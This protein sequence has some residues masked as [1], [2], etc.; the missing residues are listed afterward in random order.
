[1][2]KL[3]TSVPD[4]LRNTVESPV[5]L[6][7][8]VC[9]GGICEGM[10]YWTSGLARSCALDAGCRQR[11]SAARRRKSD[12]ST[13]PRPNE[14]NEPVVHIE[15]CYSRE[16]PE[17]SYK[18]TRTF[19]W[20]PHVELAC[21]SAAG[22][23]LLR[24]IGVLVVLMLAV[25]KVVTVVA[26]MGSC[27]CCAAHDLQVVVCVRVVES[28]SNGLAALH[29]SMAQVGPSARHVIAYGM[30]LC[31]DSARCALVI[32]SPGLM[33]LPAAVKEAGR[34]ALGCPRNSR[35]VWHTK[36]RAKAQQMEK[37]LEANGTNQLGP[38][39]ALGLCL[40]ELRLSASSCEVATLANDGRRLSE[41]LSA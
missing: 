32:S 24:L 33:V 2:R 35:P 12:P 3:V 34:E 16:C 18:L 22:R 19:N 38:R 29:R 39:R 41:D 17:I 23:F 37:A 1:M 7:A 4:T 36:R 26:V 6:G 20:I 31:F 27:W 9:A 28:H 21:L 40:K 14:H 5:S 15:R 25:A 13:S 30:E 11:G 10:M 8:E